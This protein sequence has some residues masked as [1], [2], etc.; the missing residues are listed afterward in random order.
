MRKIGLSVPHAL[1]RLS[2]CGIEKSGR[3][4]TYSYCGKVGKTFTVNEMA[5]EIDIAWSVP[6]A[7]DGKLKSCQRKMDFPQKS[8]YS[9]IQK[10]DIFSSTQA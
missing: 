7:R 8:F 6:N 4:G 9:Q 5:D 3:D 2:W 1:G 10:L